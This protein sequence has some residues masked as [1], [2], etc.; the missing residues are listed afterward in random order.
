ML[1]SENDP[2]RLVRNAKLLL[3]LALASDDDDSLIQE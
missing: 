1:E 3:E 2:G